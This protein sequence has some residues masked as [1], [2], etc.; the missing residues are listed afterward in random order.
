MPYF[1][2]LIDWWLMQMLCIP[3]RTGW[4]PL[5]QRTPSVLRSQLLTPY[6]YFRSF[7]VSPNLPGLAG[8]YVSG[9]SGGFDG[10]RDGAVPKRVAQRHCSPKL[11]A[12]DVVH[13][14]GHRFTLRC[15][16]RDGANR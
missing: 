13:R 15:N 14:R 6:Y 3:E 12:D 5:L 7:A 4:Q 2:R 10:G 1:S 11:G 8:V 16:L 9:Q